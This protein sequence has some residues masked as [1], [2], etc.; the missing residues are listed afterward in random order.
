[1]A[2]INYDCTYATVVTLTA[3]RILLALIIV[4]NLK[5]HQVNVITAFL[6]SF[7]RK[8]SIY[9][10]QP[11]GFKDQDHKLVCLL[12]K[13]IY[14]LKQ[15][16][17][18]QYNTLTK[19]LKT[20]GFKPIDEDPC[21]FQHREHQDTYLCL[22]INNIIITMAMILVIK[23]LKELLQKQYNIKDLKELRYF[24]GIHVVHN[25]VNQKIA[26]MQDAYMARILK[27]FKL[28]RINPKATLIA[29]SLQLRKHYPEDLIDKAYKKQYLKAIRS[30]T[31]LL[32]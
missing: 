14:G 19:Y 7:I 29:T 17:L 24:L 30:F 9:M 31:Q 5:A 21:I 11:K 23:A 27:S 15:A 10:Q 6:N 16:P 18:L 12:L 8:H 25:Q 13:A 22:Y 20:I 4:Y 32:Y 1:M 28:T 3:C 26:I 2:S